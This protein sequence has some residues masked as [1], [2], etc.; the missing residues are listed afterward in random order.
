MSDMSQLVKRRHNG[1]LAMGACQSL[2]LAS[3]SEGQLGKAY[4]VRYIMHRGG[5]NA[6]VPVAVVI[7]REAQRRTSVENSMAVDC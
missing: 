6:A 3:R 7:A 4:P 1:V 5:V 2:C